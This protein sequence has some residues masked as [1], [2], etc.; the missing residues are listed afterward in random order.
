MPDNWT[1]NGPTSNGDFSGQGGSSDPTGNE[2]KLQVNNNF[3]EKWFS[4]ETL[5]NFK[6]FLCPKIGRRSSPSVFEHY[7]KMF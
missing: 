6:N 2:C 3:D 1:D 4:N 5:G 7:S